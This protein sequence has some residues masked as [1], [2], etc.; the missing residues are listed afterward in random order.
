MQTN[1]SKIAIKFLPSMLDFA[2]LMPIVFLFNRLDGMQ[3]ILAD[4]D[5]GWHIRA[6]EWIAAH[7]AVP[8]HDIFSYSKP[9]GVWYAWEWLSDLLFAWLNAHGGLAT[10]GLVAIILISTVF[11]LLFLLARQKSNAIVAI[12]ITM[13]AAVASSIHWLARPHLFTLLFLVLFYAALERVRAGRTHLAGIPYLAILPVAT[14]LWTNL[15]GGFVAGIVTVGAYGCGELLQFAL[16][17]DREAGRAARTRAL[18]YF[19]CAFACLAASLVNP[20]TYHLH[21]HIFE[22]LRDPY[23]SLHI[24]EFLSLS[25]HHPIAVFFEAMLL[26]SAG[27]T[28]WSFKKGSYTEAVLLLVWA[29]G[30]LLSTRNIPLFMIVAVPPVAAMLADWLARVPEFNVAGWLRAAA[31]K[32]N[33]VAADM[34]ETDKIGRWHVVSA[35]GVLLVAALIFSPHPPDKFRPEFDPKSY[36]ATAAAM[37]GRDSG[38]RVFTPDQWGDYLIYKLYPGTRVF[39]DGRSDFYGPDFVQKAVDALNVKYGWEKTLDKFGVNTILLPPSMPL[40]G[41]LKECSRWRLVYDDGVALIFRSASRTGG[42]TVSAASGIS[43]DREITKT[44]ASGLTTTKSKSTT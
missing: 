24:S 29:H 27:A 41:A 36:P 26:L 18:H 23:Y 20:Y 15:H 14:I 31:R 19:A 40:T 2:F 8:A 38:A 16:S 30:A 6:G 13:V 22:Y 28:F 43:R 21:Q 35:A 4:G 5:T 37:I 39:V 44:Q 9:E 3:H 33:T 32:F 12:A 42:E 10:V 7:H 34:T 11:S 25:F 17:P 1:N